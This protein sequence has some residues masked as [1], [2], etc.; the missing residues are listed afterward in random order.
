MVA[1]A[2]F[3]VGCGV[4]LISLCLFLFLELIA[5]D[6]STT[7]ELDPSATLELDPSTTIDF[8]PPDSMDFCLLPDSVDLGTP[9]NELAC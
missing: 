3:T 1:V 9:P 6:P 2:T 4:C 5:L 7:I 8:R